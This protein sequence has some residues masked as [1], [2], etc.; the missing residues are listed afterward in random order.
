MKKRGHA[1]RYPPGHGGVM[2]KFYNHLMDEGHVDSKLLC[3][4]LEPPAPRSKDPTPIS[5]DDFERLLKSVE[6]DPKWHAMLL[7]SMNCCL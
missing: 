4:V 6:K 7:L 5:R 3:K 1:V 2:G